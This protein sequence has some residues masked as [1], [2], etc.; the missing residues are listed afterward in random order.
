MLK[1]EILKFLETI[2]EDSPN[3]EVLVDKS[4]HKKEVKV[5]R[6]KGTSFFLYFAPLCILH[7]IPDEEGGV[8][9]RDMIEVAL[10]SRFIR[11][12]LSNCNKAMPVETIS[13][14][15]K[16]KIRHA[17]NYGYDNGEVYFWMQDYRFQ[18]NFI[19]K[20]LIKFKQMLDEHPVKVH[21]PSGEEGIVIF[22]G[23]G[24]GYI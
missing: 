21:L 15:M 3:E 18:E 1:D 2:S 11:A 12:F 14:L 13:N 17:P 19:V 5:I 4:D 20:V 8:T 7:Q 16:I 23:W 24:F 10:I 6:N 9:I 22:S